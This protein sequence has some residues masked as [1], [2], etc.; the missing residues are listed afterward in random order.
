MR[1]D[2]EVPGEQIQLSP[3]LRRSIEVMVGRDLQEIDAVTVAKQL[4]EERLTEP[5]PNPKH[6]SVAVHGL[7]LRSHRS[8]RHNLRRHNLRLRRHNRRPRRHNLR[9]RRHN[10]RYIPLCSTCLA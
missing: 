2:R 8:R 3:L 1:D 10:L 4:G 7:S 9:P 5:D 6:Q